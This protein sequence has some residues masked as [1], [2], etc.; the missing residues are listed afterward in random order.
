MLTESGV[1]LRKCQ[2]LTAY[3]SVTTVDESWYEVTEGE[4]VHGAKLVQ[5]SNYSG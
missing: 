4:N 3:A 1:W 2:S 5:R